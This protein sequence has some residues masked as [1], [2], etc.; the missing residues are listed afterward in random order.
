MAS[1]GL[2]SLD[3]CDGSSFARLCQAS[4]MTAML[5]IVKATRGEGE[6]LPKNPSRTKAGRKEQGDSAA[7]TTDLSPRPWISPFFSLCTLSLQRFD[8]VQEFSVNVMSLVAVNCACS[9]H[10]YQFVKNDVKS[11]TATSME[12]MDRFV[13]LKRH[14]FLTG[15]PT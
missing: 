15:R 4:C 3:R 10:V 1:L 7:N 2:G 12:S 8:R 13:N 6:V 14:R 5:C 9:R 11:C